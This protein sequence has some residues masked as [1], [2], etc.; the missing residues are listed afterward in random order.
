MEQY[1]KNALF[2]DRDGVINID[3]GYVHRKE[4]FILVDGIIDLIRTANQKG[5]LV[6]VVTNQSG[7]ARG[8]YSEMEFL[9]FT[10]WMLD[11]FRSKKA[12][13]DKVY[14]SPYHPDGVVRRYALK[15]K[16]RKPGTGMID[17]AVREFNLSLKDSVM[18]GDNITDIEAGLAAGVGT[19]F[20][21]ATPSSSCQLSQ[22][23]VV[24]EL[25]EIA[26]TL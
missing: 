6:F 21:L 13:I 20:L 19:N 24:T 12:F 4:D 1:K 15:H 7:I 25:T 3:F 2:L 17:S 11:L 9:A 5:Y 22:I 26:A 18:V 10:E 16:S 14:Y 8:L 23:N